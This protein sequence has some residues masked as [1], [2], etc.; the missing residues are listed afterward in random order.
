MQNENEI[1]DA[2]SLKKSFWQRMWTIP[3]TSWSICGYS[4]SAYRTGF[5]IKELNLML[6][7]KLCLQLNFISFHL[8][9]F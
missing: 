5:Y 2:L 4:R 7:N 9:F 8:C 6:G 3:K 1:H